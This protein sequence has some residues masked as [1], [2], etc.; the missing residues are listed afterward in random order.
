LRKSGL[1]ANDIAKQ[2]EQDAIAKSMR[3][4]ALKQE[5]PFCLWLG[6]TY[7]WPRKRNGMW[8]DCGRQEKGERSSNENSKGALSPSASTY[9]AA[10]GE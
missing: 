6:M 1:R 9:A 7:S 2:W 8:R 3:G 5:I 4:H 10:V